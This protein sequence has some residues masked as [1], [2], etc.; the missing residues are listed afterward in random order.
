MNQ[1]IR[2][3]AGGL[4]SSDPVTR[5]FFIFVVLIYLVGSLLVLPLGLIDWRVP[6][7]SLNSFVSIG[8]L[9][10]A[11]GFYEGKHRRRYFRRLLPYLFFFGFFY[12]FITMRTLAQR[13]FEWK[14]ASLRAAVSRRR[15]P[16]PPKPGSLRQ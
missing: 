14:G 11:G 12:S 2:W 1:H 4:F 16:L 9:A 15:T 10:F 6:V 13:P 8:L 5:A 3:N 7:L